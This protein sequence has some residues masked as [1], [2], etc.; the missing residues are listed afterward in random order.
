MAGTGAATYYARAFL[1]ALFPVLVFLVHSSER[2]RRVE[3]A[4]K[5]WLGAQGTSSFRVRVLSFDEAAGV[6]A[7]FIR[8]GRAVAGAPPVCVV[9]DNDWHCPMPLLP[10]PRGSAPL[11]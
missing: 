9:P 7:G 10:E 1:D 6:L 2:K 5:D 11:P 3:K 8:D 4:T